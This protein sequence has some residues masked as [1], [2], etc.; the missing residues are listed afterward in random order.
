MVYGAKTAERSNLGA[1][2][3]SASQ[4]LLG[5]VDAE[6]HQILHGSHA[7]I[8]AKESLEGGWTDRKMCR[9]NGKG[10]F[11]GEVLSHIGGDLLHQGILFPLRGELGK[12]ISELGLSNEMNEKKLQI[13]LND[14]LGGEEIGL[15]LSDQLRI[16]NQ[17]LRVAE[18]GLSL[19]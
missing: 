10:Q 6:I 4:Q 7:E 3:M 16:V 2:G 8:A 1:G 14:L 15:L 19:P 9:Q 13:I 11:F 5:T 17:A 12:A 18:A